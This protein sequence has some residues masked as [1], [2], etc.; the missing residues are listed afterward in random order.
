MARR[1]DNKIWLTDFN[2]NYPLNP[3]QFAILAGVRQ[4]SVRDGIEAGIII[5]GPDGKILPNTIQNLK[6]LI[7]HLKKHIRS[8]DARNI[9]VDLLAKVNFAFIQALTPKPKPKYKKFDFKNV[10]SG[11][12]VELY[13][14]SEID[15]YHKIIS[16]MWDRETGIELTTYSPRVAVLLINDEIDKIF[17]DDEW[18]EVYTLAS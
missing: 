16:F 6:Y 14:C 9:D 15:G 8:A 5:A 17:I 7:K 13:V 18:I 1:N 3:N 11:E 10:E 4:Q 12:L 2:V